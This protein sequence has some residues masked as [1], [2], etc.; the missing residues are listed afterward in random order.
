[1]QDKAAA[2]A[3]ASASS[4]QQQAAMELAMRRELALLGERLGRAHAEAAQ[5]R[6]ERDELHTQIRELDVMVR[7]NGEAHWLIT[8]L[9]GMRGGGKDAGL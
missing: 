9:N 1:M 7:S 4:S 6:G 5:L 3:D 2:A 8:W